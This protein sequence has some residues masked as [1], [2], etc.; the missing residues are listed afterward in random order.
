VA[1][2]G[3]WTTAAML[4]GLYLSD[5]SAEKPKYFAM[6]FDQIMPAVSK[7]ECDFGV[8]IHEGR[9]TY[10][11]Y[12]LVG[13]ADLGEW[14]E[15]KTGLPVPLGGIAIRRDIPQEIT[16]TVESAIGASARYAFNNPQAADGY[17]KKYAQE[18]EPGVIRQHIDLYVNEFTLNLGL[19][20]E[21]AIQKLFE[22]AKK[23]GLI[24]PCDASLFA[25]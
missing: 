8:I 18:M 9:F 13:L 10:K 11:K 21:V 3:I 6:P 4:L 16:R 20:G 12:G 25:C 17:I 24:P 14:W 15:Q 23:Y 7:G 5:Q 22:M 2:P 1:V 19:E